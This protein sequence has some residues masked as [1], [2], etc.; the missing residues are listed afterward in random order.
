LL[1]LLGFSFLSGSRVPA[2]QPARGVPVRAVAYLQSH[3][4]RVFSTY[5]WNDYLDGKGIPVFVD[6][7]TELYTG[8]PVLQQYL[9]LDSLTTDPDAILRAYRVMYVL[10][11]PGSA[12][13]E[14]LGHDPSWRVVRRSSLSVVFHYV[15]ALA[16]VGTGGS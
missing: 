8:T 1:A 5:L 11:S 15:G 13:S 10:W 9:S 6:G 14:Y 4:G 2:G 3:P 12:L 16:S 7:R